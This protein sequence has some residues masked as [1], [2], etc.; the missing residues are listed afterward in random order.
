MKKNTIRIAMIGV[1]FVGLSILTSC[2]PEDWGI[3]CP[4]TDPYYCKGTKGCCA[5]EWTD[6][7]GTCYNSLEYCRRT[8]W[9]CSKCY[10]Q[11]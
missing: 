8:G 11:D 6:N 2:T 5:Y 10:I 7:H 3:K 1:T 4:D 9:A